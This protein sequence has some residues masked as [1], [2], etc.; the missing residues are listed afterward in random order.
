MYNRFADSEKSDK[1]HNPSEVLL[2]EKSLDRREFFS[3]TVSSAAGIGLLGL[4]QAIGSKSEK[5]DPQESKAPAA[6]NE[7][8][9]RPLGKTGVKLPVVSMG[10]MNAYNPD[11]VRRALEKGIRHF[12][13]AFAYGEGQNEIMVGNVVAEMKMRDQVVIATKEMVPHQRRG[14]SADRLRSTL[15]SMVEASLKRLKSDFVDIVYIHDV[16]SAEDVNQPGLQYAFQTLKQQGKIKF[17]GFSTHANMAVCLD[18]AVKAGFFDVVLTSFNYALSDDAVLSAVMKNAAAKGIGLV[19]MKTQ[20]SQYWYKGFLPENQQKFYDGN[21]VHK[22]MLKWSVRHPFVTTAAP[23]FTTFQQLD[24]DVTVAYN[25]DYTEEERQ[26]L[27][28]RNVKLSLGYCVQCGKCRKACPGRADVPALMR[29]HMYLACYGNL[30]QARRTLDG[31]PGSSGLNRCASCADCR[32]SCVRNVPVGK[33][34]GELK[35]LLV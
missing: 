17:A 20:C 8:V 33:R 31:I 6:E 13:T 3:K 15:V 4:S 29:T 16:S 18:A 30:D 21:L 32:V 7:M 14:L 10:V 19:A 27:K 12:D 24:E 35:T 1:P 5:A 11:L 9:T 28:D 2:K 34:I 26:F 25:L 22:A 23:G